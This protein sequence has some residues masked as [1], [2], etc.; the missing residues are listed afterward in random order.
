M[1]ANY[2]FNI[3]D[4]KLTSVLYRAASIVNLSNYAQQA[5]IANNILSNR[6]NKMWHKRPHCTLFTSLINE[7]YVI[8]SHAVEHMFL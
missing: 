6:L 8:I 5:E 3:L 4:H 7:S 1:D 2:L